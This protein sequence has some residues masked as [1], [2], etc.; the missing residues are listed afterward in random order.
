MLRYA[1]VC[2]V[3][4]LAAPAW[5]IPPFNEVFKDLYVKK[6]GPVEAPVA[7]LK[8]NVCHEGKVKKARNDFGKV[9][10]KH[11][12]KADFVGMAKKFP[13]PKDPMAQDAIK[14]GIEAAA[15]EKYKDGPTFRELI[16]K[17]E[18]PFAAPPK[19]GE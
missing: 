16:E 19:A 9:I 5:A 11:L 13:A 4:L 18:F 3:L 17:G 1:V 2:V 6:G 15:G 8:C 12:K 7:E 10:G 14:K